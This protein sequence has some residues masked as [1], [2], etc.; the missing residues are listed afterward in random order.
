[1]HNTYFDY[2]TRKK[3]TKNG[4]TVYID[5]KPLVNL[6]I[7]ESDFEAFRSAHHTIADSNTG[8]GIDIVEQG[9][10]NTLKFNFKKIFK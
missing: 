10:M 2:V 3:I 7:P 4:G 8:L 1:M 5:F 6:E 9:L